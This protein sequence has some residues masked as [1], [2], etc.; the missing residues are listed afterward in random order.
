MLTKILGGYQTDFARNWLKEG[1]SI[2]DAF[3]ECVNGALES[4][5]LNASDIQTIHVGNAAAE[6]F[7]S[8]GHLGAL[9]IEADT[10]LRGLPSARHEAA[11]ASGSVAALAATA[12][13]EAGRYE[14][15]LVME[16]NK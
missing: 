8:Q 10:S 11:C 1:I 6:M 15:A 5:H 2:V 16:S 13:L 7:L 4:S 9:A 14:L 12:E 3:K